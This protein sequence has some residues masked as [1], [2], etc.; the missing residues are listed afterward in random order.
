VIWF[1][2]GKS[3]VVGRVAIFSREIAHMQVGQCDNQEAN[4]D[5]FCRRRRTVRAIAARAKLSQ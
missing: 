5:F 4:A 2:L 3:V 1:V